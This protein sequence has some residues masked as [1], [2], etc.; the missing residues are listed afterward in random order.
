MPKVKCM[1]CIYGWDTRDLDKRRCT[2]ELPPF[3]EAVI[4]QYGISDRSVWADH[5]CDLGVEKERE[6]ED[7]EKEN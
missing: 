4:R 1:S 7:G 6:K 5:G 2:L 3:V